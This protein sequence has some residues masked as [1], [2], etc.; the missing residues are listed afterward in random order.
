MPVT[1]YPPS[2]DGYDS[3]GDSGAE[4]RSAAGNLNFES[5]LENHRRSPVAAARAQA[6]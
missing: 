4:G 6:Q 2:N 5:G 3:D 1:V